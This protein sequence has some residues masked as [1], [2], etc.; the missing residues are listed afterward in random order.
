[1]SG[2]R[3]AFTRVQP[4]GLGVSCTARRHFAQL[5]RGCPTTISHRPEPKLDNS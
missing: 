1:M 3:E 5:A 2:S 4:P